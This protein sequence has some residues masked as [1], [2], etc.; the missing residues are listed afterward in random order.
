M[1]ADR[2]RLAHWS[3]ALSRSVGYQLPDAIEVESSQNFEVVRRRVFFDEVEMVTLHRERTPLFLVFTGLYAGF[4]IMIALILLAADTLP[5]ALIFFGIALPGLVAFILR[6]IFGV[7]VVT[8][9][10]TRSRA[11]LRFG[12]RKQR[13]RETYGALCSAVRD[14]H[15]KLEAEYAAE[16]AAPAAV[17]MA[18]DIP[19]PPPEPPE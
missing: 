3:S 1:T 2:K 4:F 12:M 11:A 8:V 5:A 16:A 19:M 13:A 14:A 6:A 7:D 17:P 18:H 15:R 10:G 9:I